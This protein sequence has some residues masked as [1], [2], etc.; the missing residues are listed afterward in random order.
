VHGHVPGERP[1]EPKRLKRETV[2]ARNSLRKYAKTTYR[3][4]DI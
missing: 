1:R 2:E 4:R 3:G